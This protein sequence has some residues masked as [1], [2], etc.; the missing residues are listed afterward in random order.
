MT[1]ELVA[2]WEFVGLA[3]GSWVTSAISTQ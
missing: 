3:L 2:N 1:G